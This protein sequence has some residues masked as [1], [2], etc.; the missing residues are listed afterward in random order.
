MTWISIEY[1]EY[2][3][4]DL[5]KSSISS[6]FPRFRVVVGANSSADGGRGSCGT[7]VCAVIMVGET[8]ISVWRW[9]SE[10]NILL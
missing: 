8:L 1:M 6:V 2:V 3:S 10:S 4:A 7:A 9:S 5:R